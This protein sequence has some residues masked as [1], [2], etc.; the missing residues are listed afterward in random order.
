M[1]SS[2]TPS[3]G[4]ELNLPAVEIERLISLITHTVLL[5]KPLLEAALNETLQ[6]LFSN[7]LSVLQGYGVLTS[8]ETAQLLKAATEE[9]TTDDAPPPFLRPDGS[10]SPFG[11]IHSAIQRRSPQTE[12]KGN[13]VI[14]AHAVGVAGGAMLGFALFGVPGAILGAVL[15]DQTLP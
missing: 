14:P 11:Y 5:Q 9:S 6:E 15:A 4:A 2:A 3:H 10:P 1:T 8:D 13:I 12:E 7:Q